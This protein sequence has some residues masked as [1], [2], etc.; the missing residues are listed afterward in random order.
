[1]LFLKAPRL[2]KSHRCFACNPRI[3]GIFS[4]KSPLSVWSMLRAALQRTSASRPARRPAKKLAIFPPWRAGIGSRRDSHTNAS[5][6]LTV[7]PDSD[8]VEHAPHVFPPS[9]FA[10]RDQ[11]KVPPET[12]AQ[13]STATAVD[14]ALTSTVSSPAA[15][16]NST[17]GSVA[18]RPAAGS[19]RKTRRRRAICP[20][21]VI[22][23]QGRAAR[24]RGVWAHQGAPGVAIR[25]QPD[26]SSRGRSRRSRDRAWRRPHGGPA[27]S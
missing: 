15:L 4:R 22:S 13:I 8:P 2:K 24:S 9:A 16:S 27:A 5:H 12:P 20:V 11:A 6:S 17:N 21:I 19:R 25:R 14:A 10:Q 7:V 1:M 3:V 23:F 18:A 26:R